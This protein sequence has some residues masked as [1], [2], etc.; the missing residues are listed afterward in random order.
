MTEPVPLKGEGV[1]DAESQRFGRPEWQDDEAP[2]RLG[3]CIEQ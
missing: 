3:E 1:N 2:Q